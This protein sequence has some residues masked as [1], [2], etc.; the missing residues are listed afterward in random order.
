MKTIILGDLHGINAWKLAISNEKLTKDDRVIFLGDYFDSFD[1]SLTSTIQ[2]NNFLDIVEY[3]K[4]C[5]ASNGPEV[6]I[7]IGNHDYHYFK[8]TFSERCSGYQ[9]LMASFISQAIEDNKHHLQ[10]AYQF[11]DYLCTHAGVSQVFMNSV[12]GNDGW[13]LDTI[14]QDINELFKHK[15]KCIAFSPYDISGYRKEKTRCILACVFSLR[16]PLIS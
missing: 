11:G 8:L 13:N 15:P 16:Y 12:F 4:S 3:K 6:V 1:K 5:E 2:I 10:I 9:Y 14:C 7:L